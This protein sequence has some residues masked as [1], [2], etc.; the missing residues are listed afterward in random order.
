MDFEEEMGGERMRINGKKKYLHNEI[1]WAF[2]FFMFANI[3][4]M[5]TQWLNSL[6]VSLMFVTP[7]IILGILNIIKFMSYKTVFYEEK[8]GE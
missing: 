7:L 8:R 3:F 4:W 1:M 2:I 6:V 5:N